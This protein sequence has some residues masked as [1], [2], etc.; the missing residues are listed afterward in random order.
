MREL[1]FL[2]VLMLIRQ[3]CNLMMCYLYYL[4]LFRE[5]GLRF[6]ELS[7]MDATMC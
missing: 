4:G 7:V 2:N 5:K 1:M 6:K 3:E